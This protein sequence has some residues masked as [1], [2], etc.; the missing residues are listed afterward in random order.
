MHSALAFSQDQIAG[1]NPYAGTTQSTNLRVISSELDPTY[2]A[3][4]DTLEF[5]A[6][7]Q[8]SPVLTFTSQT[9]YNHDFLWSTEDYNRFTT[10]PGAIGVTNLPQ[11]P[12]LNN[13]SGLFCDPQLGCS[14][15]LEIED[16]SDEHAWQ[17]SQEFRL[18]SSFNGPVNFSFGGNY[19]HY[20]TE[21]NYYVFS[22]ALTLISLAAVIPNPAVPPWQPGVSTDSFCLPQPHQY[23]PLGSA[24][25]ECSY[26]DPNP[27]GSLNNQGHNY[28]LSQN[29]YLLN[30]Y[31]SFGEVYYNVAKDFKLT[32][33]GRWT[34]DQKH[35]IDIPSEIA[36]AGYGYPI[37]GV[38][39]Q[40]WDALTGRFVADWTP[41]LSFTD[42]TLIYFSAAHGYK[43]GGAN[44]PGAELLRYFSA[45]ITNPIHPL[46]FKPEYIESFELGTKNTTLDGALTL[47]GDVFYYNYTGYQI[48]RIVDRS[49]INDNF[50]AHVEGAEFE[51]NWEPL[52]GLKFNLAQGFEDARLDK[53]AQSVDLLDRT[54]GMPGW[55]VVRP[56]Y[57]QASNCILP[58][59]VIF[60]L[61]ISGG[62]GLETA[63]GVAY[64]QHLDPVTAAPY[65]ANPP[66]V[67]ENP[68][69]VPICPGGPD[70][71]VQYPGFDPLSAPNNGQ[72]FDKNLG[73]NQLP[74]AP[75]FTTSIGADYT[76]PIAED[77]AATL[78]ADFYWQSQS[79]ARVF[80]DPIDNIHGYST[81]NLALILSSTNGWQVM[82]YVKNV[83]NVT[84][85]TGTF[86]NSDD[87]DLTTNIFLTDPRLFGVRVTKQLDE[88]NGF[89][90]SEWTGKDFFTG[91]FSDADNGKPLLWIELGGGF[92]IFD[93]SQEKLNPPFFTKLSKA[94]FKSPLKFE[95]MPTDGLEESAK[96]SFMPPDSDWVL[97]ASVRYG[98]NSSKGYR[99]QQ[100][101]TNLGLIPT[102]PT[103]DRHR[104]AET[105]ASNTESHD[106][107]DFMAGKDF[108]LGSLGLDGTSILS[109]GLRFAQFRTKSG[110]AVYSDPDYTLHQGSGLPQK[111]FH[112]FSARSQN[113]ASFMGLGP[114]ISWNAS[115]PLSG[116]TP[117]R[118]ITFDWGAN[119]AV[120]FGRQKSEGFH[121]TNGKLST[122]FPLPAFNTTHYTHGP[123]AHNRSRMV[124]VPNLGGFAGLSFHYAN[125]KVSFGYRIDEFLG[126][127]DGGIDTY[128][129][130]NFGDSGPFVNLTLG[131]GG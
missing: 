68:L 116:D 127:M 122:G 74:N 1:G 120:L 37:A 89:W 45:D 13:G 84:A 91:L 20:E 56:F 59:Y 131:L 71:G 97:S 119:A 88:A 3:K 38:T 115:A 105:T 23:G 78:H 30:S 27:L 6:N 35:F 81:T 15:R 4:N 41:D 55:S 110:L 61:A 124:A 57:D 123:Y 86:L 18:A 21:E 130:Y 62:A 44:P 109:G 69:G 31:A 11:L 87:T 65:V 128:K 94:G 9:G 82:G 58:N 10:T 75:H 80:E 22:N 51:A 2:K 93:D 95:D 106:I 48:S 96:I 49:A 53:G 125:A 90:G 17:F 102:Q 83:F 7:W 118:Q 63:C 33:G 67:L 19:L 29:P 52:P 34:E 92:D 40:Q 54:G 12:S 42:K 113:K 104:Y 72:G 8:I 99:H 16:L 36:T 103:F 5:N 25:V 76:M 66:G 14:N 98:R 39:N 73:G 85:I 77:W 79:W 32:F 47:N 112:N 100:T 46:T 121:Q 114:T 50:N 126:A 24:V 26:I 101:T 43:A 60:P 28:F 108:G 111:Y 64:G 70:C 129:S 117:D 107:F